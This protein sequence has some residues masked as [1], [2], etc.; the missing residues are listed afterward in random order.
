VTARIL[1]VDDVA[2]N[3]RLLEARL[4]AE[5]FEVHTAFNGRDALALAREQR[6]DL[7]LLDVVMPDMTGFE[8]CA[9]LKHDPHTAHVPVIMV[10][11]LDQPDDRVKGL[12]CGADDFLTKPVSDIALVTRVKSL[13]RLKM[14]T[15]ELALRAAAMQSVGCDSAE[16]FTRTG[17][18]AGRILVVDD[19]ENSTRRI[20]QALQQPF[21]VEIT[22]DPA[23]A[24]AQAA[25]RDFDLVMI[26]L[27]LNAGDG[28]RLCTQ[29]KTIDR[30]RSTPVLLIVDADETARLMRALDLGVNDYIIRPIDVNELRARVRTQL[31]RRLYADRLRHMVSSAVELAITDPL[32][33][34]YNRRYL[35]AHLNSAVA[36]AAETEKPVCVLLFDVDHFKTINDTYG[37]DSGDDILKDFAVRRPAAPR[38]ARDRSCRSLRR[39]GIRARHAGDGWG[40]CPLCGG[41]AAQR[42]GKGSVHEPFRRQPQHDG[43]YRPGGMAGAPRHRRGAVQAR[44]SSALRGEARRPQ[45]GRRQRRLIGARPVAK[46]PAILL[47]K[48]EPFGR[49]AP[50][51]ALHCARRKRQR[52]PL[53]G[54]N[55]RIPH[56][57]AQVRRISWVRGVGRPD[58]VSGL[59][60]QP[61]SGRPLPNKKGARRRPTRRWALFYLILPSLKRTCLRAFGSYFR[62]ASFSVMVRLFFFVT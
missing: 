35:D 52:A 20:R 11:S 34:L 32:T 58:V 31:R 44:G 16:I 17:E 48:C 47:T 51:H 29:I 14:V 2:A 13:V 19:R 10:T 54:E 18:I 56:G 38:R 28:L 41:T 55:F 50:P 53:L 8:V 24:V 27:S 22:A 26:S 25:S 23:D 40:F 45:S 39:R 30:L 4:Q 33:G 62:S 9:A 1:V 36:R 21:E 57:F 3:A 5:Y 46:K 42:R 37:H 61:R 43:Q 49:N 59:L 7:V 60:V 15:D 6:F 12:D